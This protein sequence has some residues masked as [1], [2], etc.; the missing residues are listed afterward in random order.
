MCLIVIN[1]FTQQGQKSVVSQSSKLRE[2]VF[3][4]LLR[5]LENMFV[6]FLFG[7]I[8][9]I[10]KLVFKFLDCFFYPFTQPLYCKYADISTERTLY[11]CK[12]IEKQISIWQSVELLLPLLYI[13]Y[14]H[15]WVCVCI[16]LYRVLDCISWGI[17]QKKSNS[18]RPV[19]CQIH[20]QAPSNRGLCILNVAGLDSIKGTVPP[21]NIRLNMILV[22]RSYRGHTGLDF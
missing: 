12:G 22:E 13:Q 21:D 14:R 8:N 10:C 5:L 17:W 3:F 16:C 19:R 15:I 20:Q 7:H 6:F 2:Y 1:F 18:D 4:M 9:V 11:I